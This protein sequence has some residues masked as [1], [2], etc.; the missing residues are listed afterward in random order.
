MLCG[1]KQIMAYRVTKYI[2]YSCHNFDI[3]YREILIPEIIEIVK[4][5]MFQIFFKFQK[6]KKIGISLKKYE[7][8]KI[9]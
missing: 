8:N 4:E 1:Y 2:R 9:E 7:D 3:I 6:K 5:T